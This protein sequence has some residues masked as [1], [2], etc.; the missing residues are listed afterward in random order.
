MNIQPVHEAQHADGFVDFYTLLA[1]APSTGTDELREQINSLYKGAQTDRDHRT[2]ARRREALLLLELLPQART[3]LLDAKRRR[4]YDAYRGAV[5]MQSPR[6]PFED[7]LPT[8]LNEREVAPA[9]NDIL[10]VSVSRRP[11]KAALTATLETPVLAEPTIV[12]APEPQPATVVVTN[13]LIMPS[14]PTSS[15]L[16]LGPLVG[17][18]TTFVGL[19]V[20]L[21]TLA[22]LPFGV[23]AP[24]AIVGAVVVGYV[25]S[26]AG[27]LEMET[28]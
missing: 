17:G 22:A 2:P 20:T 12:M 7:F 16:P 18:A 26:L 27:D 15:R 19:A 21:P 24:L 5:E 3:I 4:R 13:P 8:L 25:F 10:S 1:S 6:M 28:A 9:T 11:A 23:C 14:P